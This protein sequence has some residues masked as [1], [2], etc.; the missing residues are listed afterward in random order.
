MLTPRSSMKSFSLIT[1]GGN[2]NLSLIVCV[3]SLISRTKKSRSLKS[4]KRM[5]RKR[6]ERLKRRK[7]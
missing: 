5:Q 7:N 3:E 1:N 2:V 4:R 6:L